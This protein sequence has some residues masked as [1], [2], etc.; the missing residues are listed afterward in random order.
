M[1]ALSALLYVMTTFQTG[2]VGIPGNTT[3]RLT[4]LLSMFHS[5]VP[6]CSRHCTNVFFFDITVTGQWSSSSG[7]LPLGSVEER[8][9]LCA[10]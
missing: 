6:A 8:D 7:C 2:F 9:S 3:A 4:T 5:D 10:I 1:T